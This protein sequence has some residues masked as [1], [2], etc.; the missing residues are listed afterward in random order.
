MGGERILL[1][2]TYIQGLLSPHDQ[3]HAA[4][5]AVLP[6]VE[7]ALEIVVTDAVAMELC[8]ALAGVNRSAAMRFVRGC[9]Q[10]PRITTVATDADLFSRGLDLYGGRLDKGW[11]LTDCISFV[12]M[13]ERGISL[14]ATS[15]HHFEQAGFVALLRP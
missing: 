14:A 3:H 6:R 15:D 11:S 2:T 9:Q 5:V 7:Q 12:V 1:D 8:N 4:A 13:Q 10:N